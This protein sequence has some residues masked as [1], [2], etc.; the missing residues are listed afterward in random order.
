MEDG[1]RK[2]VEQVVAAAFIL[3]AASLLAQADTVS[4]GLNVNGRTFPLRHVYASAQPGFFDRQSEDIR[5]LLTDVPLP[6]DVRGEMFQ[7]A[8]MARQGQ[9]HAVEVVLNAK[10]DPIS[11]ALFLQEFDGMAS[12]SGMH[13]FQPEAMARNRVAGR[14]FA[15]GSR[16][17]GGVTYHYEATFSAAIPRPPTTE[18]TAAALASPAGLAAAA[19]LKAI[20]TGLEAFVATLTDRAAAGC[21]DAAAAERFAE[22][23]AETPPDS[24]VVSLTGKDEDARVA[25]VQGTRDGI[26]IEFSLKLRR[27]NGAWR[28]DR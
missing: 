19:H 23:R 24:R 21:R 4:G 18:E 26:I 27:H 22:V 13:R 15:E 3:S 11:G 25:T 20:R 2:L 5:V 12:V 28:I 17:F 1:Q 16:T 10:G 6:E 14:M 7:L 9:L 8:R